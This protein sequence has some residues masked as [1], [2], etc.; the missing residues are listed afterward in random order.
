MALTQSC[1]NP[2]VTLKILTSF[3]KKGKVLP[4][5]FAFLKR[6]EFAWRKI[7]GQSGSDRS[8]LGLSQAML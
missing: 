8:H 3:I 4:R 6:A 7:A 2:A 1:G 5:K